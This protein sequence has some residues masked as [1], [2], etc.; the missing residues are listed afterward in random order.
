MPLLLQSI[1][2]VGPNL[3]LW[4][5]IHRQLMLEIVDRQCCKWAMTMA[6]AMAAFSAA[7]LEVKPTILITLC[8]SCAS[9]SASRHALSCL[10]QGRRGTASSGR[11]QL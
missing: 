1:R 3:E 2:S 7:D 6:H 9:L 8:I 10:H 5:W 11:C 4:T